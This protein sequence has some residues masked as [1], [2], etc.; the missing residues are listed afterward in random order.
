MSK[1]LP[2]TTVTGLLCLWLLTSYVQ[3]PAPV[4]AQASQTP[5]PSVCVIVRTYWGHAVEPQSGL[6]GLIA[7]LQRQTWKQWEAILMVMD[8]RPFQ[9]LSQI[10]Q[11]AGDD[12][13][14]TFAEW[15]GPQFSPKTAGVWNLGYHALLYNLTDEAIRACP[16]STQWVLATNGDN[17]YADTFF[18]QIQSSQG[19]DVVAF[20]FYSRYQRST[21][22]PCERFAQAPGLPACKPNKLQWCHTDLGANAFNFKRLMAEDKRFGALAQHSN[23]LTA[24]HYDGVMAQSMLNTGWKVRHVT[25]KCLFDHSPSPQRCARLGGVW[26]DSLS[27]T[28]TGGA[29]SC[30]SRAEAD[31]KS[32][33][34]ES[35]LEEITVQLSSDGNLAAFSAPGSKASTSI[36]CLRQSNVEQQTVQMMMMFGPLCAADVDAPAFTT[37]PYSAAAEFSAQAGGLQQQVFAHQRH[38]PQHSRIPPQPSRHRRPKPSYRKKLVP[39][40]QGR[41]KHAAGSDGEL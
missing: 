17:E 1:F 27:H 5:L 23:G 30:I 39:R 34:S 31:Q 9:E 38:S 15:N 18:E 28:P 14:W 3:L 16:P 33:S 37:L 22:A 40:W 36:Q 26:D 19:S 10:V 11:E 4:C 32:R 20:D 7:S 29:G 21:A 35:S 41:P 12:R 25:D 2:A 8:S 24:D 6:K 13:I